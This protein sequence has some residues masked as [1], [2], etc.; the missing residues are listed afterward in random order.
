MGPLTFK[1]LEIVVA[2]VILVV[3]LIF[4]VP[5]KEVLPD[6][7]KSCA[8]KLAKLASVLFIYQVYTMP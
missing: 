1:E 8:F 6:V 5:P 3:P 4:T 2:P 7:I